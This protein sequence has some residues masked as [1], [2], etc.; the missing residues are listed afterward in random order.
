MLPI[1]EVF[2]EHTFIVCV[3][4]CPWWG[5]LW[6]GDA[7]L[8]KIT[9]KLILHYSLKTSVPVPW[10]AKNYLWYSKKD[11]CTRCLTTKNVQSSPRLRY[12][13]EMKRTVCHPWQFTSRFLVWESR[14][15]DVFPLLVVL[16]VTAVMIFSRNFMDWEIDRDKQKYD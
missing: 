14:L 1:V 13:E 4:S 9:G 5:L 15:L 8:K 7:F 6:T 3:Q 12:P 10:T 2:F 16:V 11:L